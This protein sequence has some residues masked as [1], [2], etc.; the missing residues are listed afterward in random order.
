ME[1]SK[2]SLGTT[3]STR[4]LLTMHKYSSRS[5]HTACLHLIHFISEHFEL[6]HI[7]I[8]NSIHVLATR[9]HYNRIITNSSTNFNSHTDLQIC[10]PQI[11]FC[12]KT[13]IENISGGMLLC[14]PIPLNIRNQVK[15]KEQEGEKGHQKYK[16]QNFSRNCLSN[17]WLVMQSVCW[18]FMCLQQLKL[19]KHSTSTS[20]HYQLK[21]LWAHTCPTKWLEEDRVKDFCEMSKTHR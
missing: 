3:I 21:K 1:Q 8:T 17:W 5:V 9:G 2:Q 7:V 12:L 16:A 11:A 6:A 19:S 20:K 14:S 10:N 13:Q 15:T 18:R 4:V